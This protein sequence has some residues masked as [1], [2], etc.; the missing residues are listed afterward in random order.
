MLEIKATVE[1]DKEDKNHWLRFNKGDAQFIHD[2]GPEQ[3]HH[4]KVVV[5]RTNIPFR[6]WWKSEKST[7]YLQAKDGHSW[8]YNDAYDIIKR[9]TG[10]PMQNLP[11]NPDKVSF[12]VV[13]SNPFVISP[14]SIAQD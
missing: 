3:M 6:I 11:H 1:I 12:S 5:D 8:S 4:A 9:I 14:R 2:R 10:L 7:P 13:S